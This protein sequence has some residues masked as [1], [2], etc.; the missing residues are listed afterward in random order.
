MDGQIDG[1]MDQKE[2]FSPVV[3]P[4]MS[5]WCAFSCEL[6]SLDGYDPFLAGLFYVGCES[7]PYG[8]S[9]DSYRATEVCPAERQT[10]FAYLIV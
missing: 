1:G 3:T 9:A 4:M 5:S 6:T 2:W 10:F 8:D 7:P